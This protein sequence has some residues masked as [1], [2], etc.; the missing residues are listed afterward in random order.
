MMN[1][2]YGFVAVEGGLMMCT[3][4]KSPNY[5]ILWNM[6]VEVGCVIG[7]A[8]ELKPSSA[9]S[10]SLNLLK[11]SV[12]ISEAFMLRAISSAGKE[13]SNKLLLLLLLL[14]IIIKR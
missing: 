8:E 1:P 7:K 14:I 2:V 3:H 13:K 9:A 11:G 6:L 4:G 5:Q 10:E 12:A